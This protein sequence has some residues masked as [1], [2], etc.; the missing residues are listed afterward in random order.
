MKFPMWLEQLFDSISDSCVSDVKG[1][2]SGYSY[3]WSQPDENL[4]GAWLLE[5]APS[6]IE[7]CGGKV[8]GT[9][10]FGF[11]H[12]DLLA[13]PN[14]LDKV[15]FNCDPLDGEEPHLTLIGQ[16]TK[17][18]V[19]VKIFFKPFDDDCPSRVFDMN[20]GGWRER[21]EDQNTTAP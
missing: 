15:E 9:S 21:R 4:C 18:E 2:M 16:K 17:R 10:G 13:L 5:I 8:D 6:V 3:R 1:R 11:A 12:V 20:V 7:I 19:V 14:C